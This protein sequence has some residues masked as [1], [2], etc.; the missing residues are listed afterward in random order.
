M[1]AL[2]AVMLLASALPVPSPPV[3]LRIIGPAERFAPGIASTQHDEIRLTLSPDGN[4][5]LWFSRNR[6]GGPGGYDIWISHREG[7]RWRPATPVPF[8]TPGR[9][10]DP[11]FSADGRVVYFCSDRAGGQGGDDLYRVSMG[12]DGRFGEPVNLGPA[13]NSAADEFAPML[14]PDGRTLLFSSDRAG[15]AGGHD[16]YSAAMIGGVAPPARPL[17]GDLNT[18]AQEFDA[19]FLGDGRTVVF[20]RAQDFGSAPVRQFIAYERGGC[21]DAGHALPSP[22]NAPSGDSYGAMLDG[23]RRDTLTYSARRAGGEGL[24]LYRVRYRMMPP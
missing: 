6:P 11:A 21:Y 20:A 13:V 3:V 9:D 19:T 17:A 1:K 15:G 14:S 8:N 23:S 18:A 24:D 2:L 16:L 4:T 7:D 5:A 22:V 12:S 10:F